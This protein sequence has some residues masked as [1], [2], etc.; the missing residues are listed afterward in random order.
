M[1]M[2][3]HDYEQC[4][5]MRRG[6]GGWRCLAYLGRVIVSKNHYIELANLVFCGVCAAA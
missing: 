1:H 5:S 3:D 2:L 4:V 6:E